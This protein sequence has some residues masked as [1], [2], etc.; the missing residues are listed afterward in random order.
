[1]DFFEE[2]LPDRDNPYEIDLELQASR[3]IGKGLDHTLE[4]QKNENKYKYDLSVFKYYQDGA[5]HEKKIIGFIEIEVSKKWNN[6]F[7]SNWK[8]YSF[9]RRKVS[10]YDFLDPDYEFDEG[11]YNDIKENGDKTIYIIFNQSLTDAFCCDIV[12]ISKFTKVHCEV[13]GIPYN[14]SF[15]RTD[16][17][18]PNVK[19]GLDECV[20]YINK[21]MLNNG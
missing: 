18:D 12:T 20:D 15:L 17:Q 11:F 6:E 14:D 2:L 21:F 19:R 5:E 13:V 4:L 10:S 1:M 16:L 3:L 8:T 9:L 7:P